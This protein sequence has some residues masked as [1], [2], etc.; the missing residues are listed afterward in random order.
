[1]T[2]Q[3]EVEQISIFSDLSEDDNSAKYEELRKQ[4]LKSKRIRYKNPTYTKYYEE[5]KHT[6]GRTSKDYETW[7]S[8]NR[9]YIELANRFRYPTAFEQND[10]NIIQQDKDTSY[11]ETGMVRTYKVCYHK[12]KYKHRGDDGIIKE[13]EGEDFFY[14][15]AEI[16]GTEDLG[17]NERLFIHYWLIEYLDEGY[18]I[19]KLNMW[20]ENLVNLFV[21]GW[22]AE[23]LLIMFMTRGLEKYYG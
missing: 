21:Q 12:E 14:N 22:T 3:K 8:M 13:F 10:Y 6:D 15:Y 5:D 18:P 2:E 7:G 1:M 19:T 4:A 11:I 17:I 23:L 20:L 16:I 9:L